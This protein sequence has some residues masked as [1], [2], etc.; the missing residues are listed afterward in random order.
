M[1]N[2]E[3]SLGQTFDK[4]EFIISILKE[5]RDKQDLEL[6]AKATILKQIAELKSDVDAVKDIV[7]RR[8]R[9]KMTQLSRK[10]KGLGED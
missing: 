9:H 6:K 3:I 10:E 7:S 5:V 4:D 2:T 1:S 8:F